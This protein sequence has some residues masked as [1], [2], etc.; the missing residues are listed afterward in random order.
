MCCCFVFVDV[1]LWRVTLML[2]FLCLSL[3]LIVVLCFFPFV[4]GSAFLI[5]LLCMSLC[6]FPF[7]CV[8]G[9]GA[10][11]IVVLWFVVLGFIL[12]VLLLLLFCFDIV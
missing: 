7:C 3:F 12:N 9:V 8:F 1:V 2:N 10:V 11:A 6:V 4:L 5:V